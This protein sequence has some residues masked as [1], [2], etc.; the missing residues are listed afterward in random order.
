MQELVWTDAFLVGYA[1]MDDTHREFVGLVDA[2]LECPDSELEAKLA[3]FAA[4]ARRHFGEEN[5]W[6]N[7]SDFPG[8]ECHIDE[9]GAVM[10]SVEQV[11]A[12][13]RAGDIQNGRH[14]AAELARWFPAH[15]DHLDSALAH[16]LVKRST[17]GAPVVLRRNVVS[18]R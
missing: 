12:L 2:M 3:D 4:H 14:L 9:H 17:G 5:K 18:P 1:P 13:V 8:R 10:N 11:Q 6:M 7:D 15:A 16:W